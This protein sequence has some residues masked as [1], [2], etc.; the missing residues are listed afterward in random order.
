[1]VFKDRR[2]YGI[3]PYLLISGLDNKIH[4]QNTEQRITRQE[5][6]IALTLSLVVALAFT[7][8]IFLALQN[9]GIQDWDQHLAYH[10]VPRLTVSQYLQIPLWNPYICGG[11]VMLAHPESPIL[12]PFFILHV[13]FGTV[14]AIKL[15]I[16]LHLAIG[17]MGTYLLARQMGLSRLPACLPPAIYMLSSMFALSLTAG[18]TWF[19]PV[20]YLPWCFFC[21]LRSEKNWIWLWGA[22]LSLTLMF[23]EGGV[24]PF[25]ITSLFLL[26]YTCCNIPHIG[27]VRATTKLAVLFALTIGL[28]AVKLLPAAEFM[29]QHPRPMEDYSGYSVQSLFY[30]LFSAD[31]TLDAV[32]RFVSHPGFWSGMSYAMDENGMYVGFLSGLL[33]LAGLLIWL[34]SRFWWP[35][36]LLFFIFLWLSFGDRAPFSLWH[37]L[38]KF[39]VYESMRVAQRF[40]IIMMLYF[41]IIAGFGL[42]AVRNIAAARLGNDRARITVIMLL[43]IVYSNLFWINARVWRDAFSIP[44]VK[45]GEK[46]EFYQVKHAGLYDAAGRIVGR[47]TH[48]SFSSEYPA[49]LANIGTI[50]CYESAKVPR[51]A[52][53]NDSPE[54]LGEVFLSGTSGTVAFT[55]WTP[56]RL[57]ISVKAERE[58]YIIINQ[59]YYKGWR[60][61]GRTVLNLNGLMGVPVSATDRE[62]ELYYLPT[63]FL[64]GASLSMITLIGGIMMIIRKKDRFHPDPACARKLT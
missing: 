61:D 43:A 44:P 2:Q 40:R 31:Q 56:N 3:N 57:R 20:V 42:E 39:P 21:M 11:T 53:P 49:L 14:I 6:Y 22:A 38:H 60:S 52:I 4:M 17:L 24:Y 9:W 36:A 12:T 1:M 64:I 16:F 34:R 50:D 29:I 10:E 23:T 15:E 41:A 48:S 46:A 51:L 47:H 28:S 26:L 19:L 35:Q 30:S 58:G 18:V 59:N 32:S 7:F 5:A 8:P 13:V 25:S 27:M 63:S 33:F 37:L 62:I 54:Y 45:I 55:S